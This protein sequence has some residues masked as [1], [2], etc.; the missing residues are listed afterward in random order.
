MTSPTPS[1]PTSSSVIEG[2]GGRKLWTNGSLVYTR[3]GLVLLFFWLLWGDFAWCLKDR[4]VPVILPFLLRNLGAS[5]TFAGVLMGVAPQMIGI[6]LGPAIGM[7]SD[8]HR[9]PRGRRIPFLLAATPGTV[10]AMAALAYCTEIGRQIHHAL[11]AHSPG[12][13]QV[14]LL[15]IAFFWIVFEVCMIVAYGVFNALINDVVPHP[16]IG[17]FFGFFRAISLIAGMGFSFFLGDKVHS[18]YPA[19]FL[20]MGALF[21]LGFALMCAMVREGEYPPPEEM[22]RGLLA[23]AVQ[24]LRESFGKSYYL[25]VF[26]SIA[27]PTITFT[28]V[29]LYNTF[30]AGSVGMSDRDYLWYLGLTYGISLALSYP[31]G[32][33]ADRF[34]PL[35]VALVVLALYAGVTLWGGLCIA[36]PWQFAVALVA[37]GVLSGCWYTGAASLAQM[38]LPREK[39]AQFSSAMGIITA[40]LGVM[41]NFGM[42]RILDMSHHVYRYSYLVSFA[43]AMLGL[44]STWMLYVRFMALGGPRDYRAP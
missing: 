12:I 35:R 5:D 3:S 28:P 40:G 14:T 31:L 11:G 38:L 19:I 10:A 16:V 26:L 44:I 24:Y 27:L 8:R 6:F 17:R 15:D 18:H 2:P 4:T 37:F 41:V 25:W 21:G 33:L 43:L 36:K 30:F 42:G 1:E 23:E 13:N 7:K 9:G 39:F 22:R 20:T 29:N 34:H 32:A